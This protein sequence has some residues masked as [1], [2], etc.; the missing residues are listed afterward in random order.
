M[1][2][3]EGKETLKDPCPHQ[4]S[5]QNFTLLPLPIEKK[6]PL[7][8]NSSNLLITFHGPTLYTSLT[9]LEYQPTPFNVPI[10][11]IN[12]LL[13]YLEYQPTPFN[14][15]IFT[16]N[17]LPPKNCPFHCHPFQFLRRHVRQ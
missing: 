4:V 5:F 17:N 9:Y 12:N 8:T 13:T 11:T 15:P 2:N 14:V 7:L 10:F 1:I 16:I 6:T 3:K